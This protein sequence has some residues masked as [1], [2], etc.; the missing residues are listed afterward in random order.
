MLTIVIFIFGMYANV[1]DCDDAIIVIA[2]NSYIYKFNSHFLGRSIMVFCPI[3]NF[4]VEM[5]KQ[6]EFT[7]KSMRFSSL[8][9]CIAFFLS[10][11]HRFGLYYFH[12]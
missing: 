3:A 12:S 11:W 4:H 7:I 8:S 1:W 2:F 9:V 10:T 6:N 5:L